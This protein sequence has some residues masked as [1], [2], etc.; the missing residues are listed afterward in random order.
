[1]H[2]RFTSSKKACILKSGKGGEVGGV[3]QRVSVDA[4]LAGSQEKLAPSKRWLTV[5]ET[6]GQEPAV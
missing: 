4:R 1:M 5:I 2:R 6:R 3:A